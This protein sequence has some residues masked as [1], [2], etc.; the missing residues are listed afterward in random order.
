VCLKK[1]GQVPAQIPESSKKTERQEYLS[2]FSELFIHECLKSIKNS[3]SKFSNYEHG[4]ARN[5]PR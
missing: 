2:G 5:L 1:T 3:V 4:E